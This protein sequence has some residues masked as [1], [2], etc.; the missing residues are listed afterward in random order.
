MIDAD[1]AEVYGTSTKALNQAV[2]RNRERFPSE[3]M[4]Q[5][6]RREKA[7]VVTN[8][9]HLRSLKY[10]PTLPFAFTEFGAVML[11]SVLKTPIAVQA[12]IAVVRAFIR[13]RE[14]LATH[15]ELAGKLGEPEKRIEAHDEEIANLFEAIRQLMEPQDTPSKRIG[16]HA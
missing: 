10:S 14:T 5:L 16:F 2:K 3:F 12:S 4:F 11:A 13:F 15:K 9:D 1:L 7:E 6:D 8:C